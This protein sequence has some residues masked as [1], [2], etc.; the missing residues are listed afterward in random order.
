MS[1]LARSGWRGFVRSWRTLNSLCRLVFR[2][3]LALLGRLH[4]VRGDLA[5]VERAHNPVT[6]DGILATVCAHRGRSPL[7]EKSL[8]HNNYR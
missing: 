3:V 7:S 4:G 6:F 2:Q 1:G 8:L 5:A